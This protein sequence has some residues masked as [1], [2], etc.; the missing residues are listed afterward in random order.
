MSAPKVPMLRSW[1][2]DENSSSL[3]GSSALL[4]SSEPPTLFLT[5]A[6]LSGDLRGA[7]ESACCHCVALFGLRRA[8]PGPEAGSSPHPGSTSAPHRSRPAPRAG[9]GGREQLCSQGKCASAYV[10]FQRNEPETVSLPPGAFLA[11][12]SPGEGWGWFSVPAD[13]CAPQVAPRTAAFAAADCYFWPREGNFLAQN[14]KVLSFQEQGQ[15]KRR[16]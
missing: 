6:V 15:H 9:W 3:G 14:G 16:P 1:G 10:S 5:S 13:S 7:E 8:L 12:V 4:Q 2:P 11:S